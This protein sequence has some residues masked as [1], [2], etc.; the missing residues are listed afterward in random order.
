M[1][2]DISWDDAIKASGFVNLAVDEEKKI[3]IT[4][5]KFEKV[6]KFNK[7]GVEFVADCKEEDGVVVDKK[8]TTMSSRMKK[9]LRPILENKK[10]EELVK[11]SIIKVG[12]KFDTQFSVAQ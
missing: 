10:P 8:F 11:L 5:W 2:E 3:T 9:K 6:T 1:T 12:D 4:N 7:D